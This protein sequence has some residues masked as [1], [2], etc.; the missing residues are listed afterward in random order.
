MRCFARSPTPPRCCRQRNGWRPGGPP[1][2]RRACRPRYRRAADDALEA[3]AREDAHDHRRQDD[4]RVPGSADQLHDAGLTALGEFRA[5]LAHL[6]DLDSEALSQLM[7]GTSR[8]LSASVDAWVTSMPTK[9]LAAM[10][11]DVSDRPVRRSVRLGGKSQANS[12][13]VRQASTLAAAGRGGPLQA[14]RMT[15]V[16]FTRH[17]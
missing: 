7:Q 9:R 5:S 6:K 4:S 14:W 3:P 15:A 13:I 2:R 8:S 11:T 16:L 1:A 17:P 10:H 12:R